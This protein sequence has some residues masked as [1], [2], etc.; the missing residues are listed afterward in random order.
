MFVALGAT[1][2]SLDVG[3]YDDSG[4]PVTGLVAA[5]FPVL[6]YS[7]AGANADG[8]FPAL[9]DLATLTTAWVAGG[10]KE[11]GNG[12]YRLDL[13]NAAFTAQG[14]V[15]VRG[16]ASGK[17]VLA[18]LIEVQIPVGAAASVTAG[19]TVA[20]NLDKTGYSLVSSSDPLTSQVPGSYA[21][22]SAG[23]ALGKIGAAQVIATSIV[24]QTGSFALFQG[25]DYLAVDGRSLDWIDASNSWPDLTGA[26]IAI[27]IYTTTPA[28]VVSNA[29]EVVT[30]TGPSKHV[31]WEP[32]ATITAALPGGSWPMAI[33]ATLASG[34]KITLLIGTGNI[35]GDG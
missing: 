20:T 9:S 26:S 17:H 28:G 31:R 7:L 4:L 5:T 13:D 21:P 1:S 32:T 16:E 33:V 22:G 14:E 23:A 25:R 3:V 19:V 2:I 35:S 24:S 30:P 18:P 15:R 29:G 8:T 10:V 34:H 6:T 11:R 27:I 12:V